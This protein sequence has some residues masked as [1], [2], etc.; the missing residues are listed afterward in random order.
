MSVEEDAT[1]EELLEI[2]NRP[3]VVDTQPGRLPDLV[4]DLGESSKAATGGS[5]KR[6]KPL[7]EYRLYVWI[8]PPRRIL[9]V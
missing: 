4:V 1:A 9:Y 5:K 7:N 3:A 2:L 6:K 8:F